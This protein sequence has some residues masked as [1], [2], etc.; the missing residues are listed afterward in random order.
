MNTTLT[1]QK[2]SLAKIE[3]IVPKPT[4]T[5]IINAM[6]ERARVKHE[7]DEKARQMQADALKSKILTTARKLMKTAKADDGDIRYW[8]NSQRVVFTTQVSSPELIEMIKQHE[9]ICCRFSFDPKRAKEAIRAKLNNEPSRVNLLS[10]PEA[11][12]AIDAKLEEWSM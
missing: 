3:T 8:N 7:L 6:V 12:K 2:A 9:K 10:D 11:V 5:E 4:K 1:K